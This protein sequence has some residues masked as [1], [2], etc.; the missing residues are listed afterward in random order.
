MLEQSVNP[1]EIEFLEQKAK[2]IQ[3]ELLKL[4]EQQQQIRIHILKFASPFA[5][6]GLEDWRE[7]FTVAEKM[8]I[9]DKFAAFIKH[10]WHS[11]GFFNNPNFSIIPEEKIRNFEKQAFDESSQLVMRMT[12]AAKSKPEM[13]DMILRQF[14][15]FI[16]WFENPNPI[17]FKPPFLLILQ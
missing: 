1:N 5:E 3:V 16:D 11:R 10:G 7:A 12:R 2:I 15:L 4:L 13:A 14:H 8:R 9:A 17:L 6:F